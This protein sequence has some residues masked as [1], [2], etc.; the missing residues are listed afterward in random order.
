MA[1]I[2]FFLILELIQLYFFINKKRRNILVVIN[3]TFQALLCVGAIL[4]LRLGTYQ[5][6]II[7][8]PL[9]L[10]AVLN[11]I[12]NYAIA[13][14]FRIDKMVIKR[15]NVLEILSIIYIAFSVYFIFWKG[16]DAL[17]LFNS[18]EYLDAYKE[19]HS[20]EISFHS[21][22]FEQVLVNYISYLHIPVLLYGFCCLAMKRNKYGLIIILSV[23]ISRYLWAS[24]YSSRTILFSLL[25]L[26]LI[27]SILFLDYLSK[28]TQRFIKLFAVWVIIAIVFIIFSISVSRFE[29]QELS[30][31]IYA[32]F[33]RSIVTFQDIVGTITRY[34]NGS[35]FFSY[36]INYLPID[37]HPP[38]TIRDTGTNFVPEFARLYEDFNIWFV[39]FLLA[40]IIIIVRNRFKRKKLFFADYYLIL[41]YFFSLFIGNLYKTVDFI[42]V[43]MITAIYWV[44]RTSEIRISNNDYRFNK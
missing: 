13:G 32:Y 12:S 30:E 4:Y 27:C 25:V 21:N 17:T 3:T 24:V 6:D 31:W 2:V 41:A 40:P 38:V 37:N 19:A 5:Y 1:Y 15:L 39:F 34:S 14:S 43:V 28:R 16:S 22:L 20:E 23:F 10:F 33:G 9:L 29:G 35:I 36:I 11:F 7:L 44:L 8:W 26:L 18:G 42:G